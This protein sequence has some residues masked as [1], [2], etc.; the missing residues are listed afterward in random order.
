MHSGANSAVMNENTI[1]VAD[2]AILCWFGDTLKKA[3]VVWDSAGILE[4]DNSLL[5]LKC[6]MLERA[7]MLLHFLCFGRGD[8]GHLSF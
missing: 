5:E 3:D 6:C 4:R 8:I 1:N 7:P 2:Y